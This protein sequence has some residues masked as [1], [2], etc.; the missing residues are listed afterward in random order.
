LAY[1]RRARRACGC[2]ERV[3][4]LESN[5]SD[6][7]KPLKPVIRLLKPLVPAPHLW[8]SPEPSSRL[9]S[10]ASLVRA[11]TLRVCRRRRYHNRSSV[12]IRLPLS[13]LLL[14]I[15]WAGIPIRPV[16]IRLFVL[17]RLAPTRSGCA[18]PSCFGPWSLRRRWNLG[19]RGLSR[20]NGGN[21]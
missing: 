13:R 15:R 6:S 14:R 11:E 12:L 18:V 3:G 17:C 5:K 20:S 9:A 19:R 21:E 16:V 1:R 4:P 7:G 8:P 10:S 2:Q